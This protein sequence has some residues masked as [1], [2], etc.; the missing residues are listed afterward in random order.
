MKR[1]GANMKVFMETVY[2]DKKLHWL[3]KK[4]FTLKFLSSVY[5]WTFQSILVMF[6]FKFSVVYHTTIKKRV[7]N[8]HIL[9]LRDKWNGLRKA[10]KIVY[11]VFT[12]NVAVTDVTK[13]WFKRLSVIGS[14]YAAW[15]LASCVRRP[16][17][18][19]PAL[20]LVQLPAGAPWGQPAWL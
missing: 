20:L 16:D 1:P 14:R 17:L 7:N 10:C 15:N 18:S 12:W 8:S 9:V 19:P 3:R 13:S 4:I 2:H 6:Y 11:T 5:P